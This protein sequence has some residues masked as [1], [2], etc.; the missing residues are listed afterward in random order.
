MKLL[1]ILGVV[2]L[3]VWLWRTRRHDAPRR[4]PPPRPTATGPQ[5]MIRCT[6]CSLHVPAADAIEGKNGWYCC[7]DHRQRAEP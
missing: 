3:G 1:L 2:L 5:E 6:L 4:D 7:A